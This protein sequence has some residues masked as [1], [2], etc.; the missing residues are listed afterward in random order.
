MKKGTK[1]ALI[2]GGVFLLA[3]LGHTGI[4]LFSTE[5][6]SYYAAK[7]I[8]LNEQ[9]ERVTRG[10]LSARGAVCIESDGHI[11]AVNGEFVPFRIHGKKSAYLAAM[12]CAE[13][14]ELDDKTELRYSDAMSGFGGLWSWISGIHFYLFFQYYKGVP[15]AD[16][17]VMVETGRFGKPESIYAALQYGFPDDLPAEPKITAEEAERI[18]AKYV[19]NE[20][21]GMKPELVIAFD[22]KGQA[23]LAWLTFIGESAEAVPVNAVTGEVLE[24]GEAADKTEPQPTDDNTQISNQGE[25]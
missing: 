18:A 10:A 6:G 21:I 23:A 19:L 24:T 9:P 25:F 17:Q 2:C 3:L 5:S 15:V 8:T 1:T 12:S 11:T 4:D 13:L 14:L 16:T 20:P 22:A 7:Q